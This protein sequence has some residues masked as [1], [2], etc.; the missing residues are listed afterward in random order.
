M[1]G[2]AGAGCRAVVTTIPGTREQDRSAVDGERPAVFISQI[3]QKQESPGVPRRAGKSSGPL[4]DE[5][6][7]V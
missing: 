2:R 5:M 7:R 6:H 4:R 1:M 3:Y